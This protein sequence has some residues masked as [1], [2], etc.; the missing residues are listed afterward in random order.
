VAKVAILAAAINILGCHCLLN[1]GDKVPLPRKGNT[2][3]LDPAFK[4]HKSEEGELYE[5]GTAIFEVK[6]Q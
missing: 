3:A 6:V 4:G 5:E 2:L 1:V